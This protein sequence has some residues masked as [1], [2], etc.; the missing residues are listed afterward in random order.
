V[1]Y[2][3]ETFHPSNRSKNPVNL[4]YKTC[5]SLAKSGYKWEGETCLIHYDLSGII[6][7]IH[8]VVS[9]VKQ[10]AEFKSKVVLL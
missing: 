9:Y 1:V 5:G 3:A 4:W 2:P 10:V 7:Q 8:K 6:K